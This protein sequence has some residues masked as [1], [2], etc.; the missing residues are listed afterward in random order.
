[1]ARRFAFLFALVLLPGALL[2]LAA[3][4]VGRVLLRTARGRRFLE[5]VR[6]R[7]PT[8][9]RFPGKRFSHCSESRS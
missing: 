8:L 4:A 3:F 9:G 1:V 6:R 7:F 5:R 2:A